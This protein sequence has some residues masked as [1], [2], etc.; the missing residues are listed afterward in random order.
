MIMRNLDM[1]NGWS[2]EESVI[3]KFY[4]LKKEEMESYKSSEK[5]TPV[6]VV[7]EYCLLCE[8]RRELK[9]LTDSGNDMNWYMD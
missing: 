1:K 2:I 4:N 7:M 6:H 8:M 9:A 5:R 3:E